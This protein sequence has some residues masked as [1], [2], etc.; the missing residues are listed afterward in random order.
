VG[1]KGGARGY[2][3]LKIYSVFAKNVFGVCY[4]GGAKVKAIEGSQIFLKFGR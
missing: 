3:G 2:A 4:L 1:L